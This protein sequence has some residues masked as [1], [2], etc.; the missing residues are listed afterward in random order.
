MSREKKKKR[1]RLHTER[2]ARSFLHS[3]EIHL[4]VAN[5]ALEALVTTGTCNLQARRGLD[6]RA[7]VVGGV[8]LGIDGN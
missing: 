7:W 3:K 6:L 5:I 4:V 8:V 2:P 1:A